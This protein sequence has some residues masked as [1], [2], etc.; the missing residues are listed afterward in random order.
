MR[1][2]SVKHHF[3]VQLLFIYLQVVFMLSFETHLQLLVRLAYQVGQIA[4][5]FTLSYS[6]FEFTM[7]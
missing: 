6:L 5:I 1:W 3:L 4:Y 7:L 2:P